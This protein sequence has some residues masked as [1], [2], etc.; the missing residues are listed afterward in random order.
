MRRDDPWIVNDYAIVRSISDLSWGPY[1]V[2]AVLNSLPTPLG[3]YYADDD[4]HLPAIPMSLSTPPG[5]HTMILTGIDENDAE[6]VTELPIRV[7]PEGT[8]QALNLAILTGGLAAL[9][10]CTYLV[11]TDCARRGANASSTKGH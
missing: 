1:P 7:W 5:R 9:A 6:V 8:S 10:A 11:G 4:D 3:A 2:R